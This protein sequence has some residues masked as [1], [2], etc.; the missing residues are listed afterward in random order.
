[1]ALPSLRNNAISEDLQTLNGIRVLD[2]ATFQTILSDIVH[3]SQA[4]ISRSVDSFQEAVLMLKN[5]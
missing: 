3:C 2:C 5:Q 1:M 4:S